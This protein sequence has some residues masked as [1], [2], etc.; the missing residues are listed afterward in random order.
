MVGACNGSCQVAAFTDSGWITRHFSYKASRRATDTYSKIG[1][2]RSWALN[3]S[4]RDSA[5]IQQSRT[6][7]PALNWTRCSESMVGSKDKEMTVLAFP[8]HLP[9]NEKGSVH[10]WQ[11]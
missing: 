9:H 2:V 10:R 7:T 8:L 1:M 11:T 4:G 6:N 3:R 5:S